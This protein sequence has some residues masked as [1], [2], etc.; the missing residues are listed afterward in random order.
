MSTNRR[1]RRS[2][3]TPPT[4]D[5][6]SIGRPWARLTMPRIAAEPESV[7]AA[8]GLAT[9]F[10]ITASVAGI[11]PSHNNLKLALPRAGYSRRM[12][13]FSF[14]SG[15]TLST[16]TGLPPTIRWY[17]PEDIPH[18]AYWSRPRTRTEELLSA[19][20]LPIDHSLG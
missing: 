6:N 12:A 13:R 7:N 17:R 5:N 14:P 9:W 4:S 11:I 15:P 2:A 1:G 10:I 19:K 16:Q 20:A 3:A 18:Q 8:Y